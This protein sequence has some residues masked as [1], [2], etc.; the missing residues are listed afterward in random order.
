M[1][2]ETVVEFAFVEQD[3]SESKIEQEMLFF[4]F[5]LSSNCIPFLLLIQISFQ[6]KSSFTLDIDFKRP[7]YI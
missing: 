4:R 1:Q 3:F 6:E 5:K 2:R 7:N